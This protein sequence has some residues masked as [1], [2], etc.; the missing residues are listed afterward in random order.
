MSTLIDLEY[1]INQEKGRWMDMNIGTGYGAT[2]WEINL[3]NV[4]RKLGKEKI[5]VVETHFF[6]GELPE[7]V[8]EVMDDDDA[9]WAGLEKTIE[10]ALEKAKE[11]G[12]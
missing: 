2:C 9:D 10:F 7:W 11:Y 5:V 8:F 4:D 12:L 1:W 6:D 3:G